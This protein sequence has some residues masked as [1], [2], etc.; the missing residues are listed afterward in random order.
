MYLT[1]SDIQTDLY[2]Q[3]RGSSSNAITGSTE[4][5]RAINNQMLVVAHQYPWPWRQDI[6]TIQTQAPYSTG[7]ITATNASYVVTGASTSWDTGW[8]GMWIYVDADGEWYKVRNI[9]ST[10]ALTLEQPYTGTTGGSKTYKLYKRL[11]TLP[12]I[13]DDIG[14]NFRIQKLNHTVRYKSKEAFD[15]KHTVNSGTGMPYHFTRWGIS[16]P[17]KTYTTGTITGTQGTY[18]VTGSS[19]TWLG[20]VERG[21]EIEISSTK[22]NV[23]SVESDTSLTLVQYL[24]TSPSGATYT[25]RSTNNVVLE[26]G[27]LPDT[28][29]NIEISYLRKVFKLIDDNDLFQV[30][31]AFLEVV[32]KYAM[33]ELLA[34]HDSDRAASEKALGDA[35]LETM[36]TEHTFGLEKN[37]SI[38]R[39]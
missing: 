7:T 3:I 8:T 16:Y 33:A 6:L 26:F 34:A 10:T 30:P 20:K 1:F 15:R 32:R 22:Y 25:A 35:A 23:A 2:K 11:Y 31:S 14:N 27:Y 28:T 38:E 12:A 17:L 36:L 5:K 19:T 18:T 39:H 37:I 24:Q 9:S 4:V 21:D 13:V 29:Y